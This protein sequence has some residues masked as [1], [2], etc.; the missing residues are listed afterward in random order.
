MIYKVITGRLLQHEAFDNLVKDRL[1][2]VIIP[3]TRSFTAVSYNTI[4]ATPDLTK[5]T[6]LQDTLTFQVS[7]FSTSY[8]EVYEVYEVIRDRLHRFEGVVN[9]VES[10]IIL[11]SYRD[12][13]IDTETGVYSTIME[14]DAK[15]KL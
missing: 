4:V 5:D 10:R 14:F 1:F 12:Q 11:T 7:I 6:T 8:A 3:Q 2:P 9:G 15:M 13:E